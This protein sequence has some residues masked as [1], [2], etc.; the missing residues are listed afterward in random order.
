MKIYLFLH[1][2]GGQI[3]V[4]MDC[5]NNYQEYKNVS[6]QKL[7]CRQC[8]LS[9]SQTS[10]SLSPS[11]SH[12]LCLSLCLSL[13]LS[14]FQNRIKLLHTHKIYLGYPYKCIMNNKKLSI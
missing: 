1:T 4:Y 8:W 6:F 5:T 7:N 10:N 9:C 3:Y 12:P 2:E 13:S 14:P 11:V